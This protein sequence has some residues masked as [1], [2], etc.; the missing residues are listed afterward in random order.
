MDDPVTYVGIELLGQ[1]KR[2]G[3]W[4]GPDNTS[5]GQYSVSHNGYITQA[6]CFTNSGGFCN[7]YGLLS[8]TKHDMD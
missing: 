4:L 3:E 2:M 7:S 1:L 6:T 8:K 5:G